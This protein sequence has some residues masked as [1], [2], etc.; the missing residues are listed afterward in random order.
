LLRALAFYARADVS[1]DAVAGE[2]AAQPGRTE[3]SRRSQTGPDEAVASRVAAS[4]GKSVYPSV[5]NE[6]LSDPALP[7]PLRRLIGKTLEIAGSFRGFLLQEGTSLTP[8]EARLA[9]ADA[10]TFEIVIYLLALIQ[11]LLVSEVGQSEDEAQDF[12]IPMYLVLI[13]GFIAGFEQHGKKR[14]LRYVANPVAEFQDSRLATDFGYRVRGYHNAISEDPHE[15]P[16]R[17]REYLCQPAAL[18]SLS[19]EDAVGFYRLSG[20]LLDRLDD[21]LVF[22]FMRGISANVEVALTDCFAA[23]NSRW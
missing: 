5:R 20:S 11:H 16:S 17:M 3:G 12:V 19:E 14:S 15:L 4:F 13:Y 9:G 18:I 8:F 2:G 23:L 7:A 10:L 6:L 1:P 21:A 22:E